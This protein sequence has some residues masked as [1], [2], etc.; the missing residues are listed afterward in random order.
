MK[1][2]FDE[3]A[4]GWRDDGSE[5]GVVRTELARGNLVLRPLLPGEFTSYAAGS[6]YCQPMADDGG[7]RCGNKFVQVSAPDQSSSV[8]IHF[9]FSGKNLGF[10][11]STAGVLG[12]KNA[13]C[14]IDGVAYPFPPV[15]RAVT[16][17]GS[18]I[19]G[20]Y[21]YYPIAEDLPDGVHQAVF[22]LSGDP[23]GASQVI[24]LY[25]IF[26]EERAG[27]R[28]VSPTA[29]L[30][31][32]ALSAVATRQLLS[33]LFGGSRPSH[34]FAAI[35]L[36]NVTG[37]DCLVTLDKAG[38][39]FWREIVPGNKTREINFPLPVGIDFAN[40]GI[41]CQTANAIQT[42]LWGYSL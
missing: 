11:M 16:D 40:Y 19:G 41:T 21:H 5:S 27:Y 25:G 1:N 23:S 24:I 37:S 36:S 13:S 38:A 2:I 32:S 3:Q 28:P 29:V 39:T 34:V 30:C 4:D 12:S 18:S 26:V 31:N 14:L 35:H 42:S 8:R 17:P 22:A 7:V 20:G 9:L 15:P 33:T 10:C 6:A